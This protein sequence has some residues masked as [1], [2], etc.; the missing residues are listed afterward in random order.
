MFERLA[1][2]RNQS[3]I[4]VI[5]SEFVSQEVALEII[6]NEQFGI[7]K[8]RKGFLDL[9]RTLYVH[10]GHNASIFEKLN[11]SFYCFNLIIMIW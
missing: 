7:G 10:V 8:L 1:Y 6:Q 3:N 2:G 9:F 11:V 4:N 5:S